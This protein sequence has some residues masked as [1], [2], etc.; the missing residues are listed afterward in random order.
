ML[1][2][3]EGGRGS[4]SC[5]AA[6]ADALAL[7]RGAAWRAG[8][9]GMPGRCSQEKGTAEARSG[10]RKRWWNGEGAGEKDGKEKESPEEAEDDDAEEDAEAPEAEVGTAEEEEDDD[11]GGRSCRRRR[12]L[13][14]VAASGAGGGD[15]EEGLGICRAVFL[16]GRRWR[17]QRQSAGE[18]KE[19]QVRSGGV[20]L[21]WLGVT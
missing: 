1:E 2:R 5:S 8:V 17:G 19:A 10:E 3:R 4:G 7:P 6:D 15:E 12:R 16:G 18:W 20:G 14:R 13:R 9:L 21:L 11:G